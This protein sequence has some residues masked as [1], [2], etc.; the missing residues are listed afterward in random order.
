[1]FSFRSLYRR[2]FPGGPAF[3]RPCSR[4]QLEEL[5]GR[6][7]LSNAV[8]V[9]GVATEPTAGN[10]QVRG[11]LL[12]TPSTPFTI[13][14]FAT[15][16]ATNTSLG[17]VTVFTDLNGAASFT[18]TAALPP[19]DGTFFTATSTDLSGNTSASSAPISL[20]S[21]SI[22]SFTGFNISPS[23]NL[24][25]VTSVY[26]LLLNRA[27]DSSALG[28]VTSLNNGASPSGIVNDIESS[29]EYLTDQVTALY[30]RYL[31][32]PPDATGLQGW[33]SVLQSGGTL[34][35]VGEHLV[36]SDEFFQAQGGTN[37]AFVTALYSQVL[38]RAGSPS[39]I[40]GWVNFLNAGHTR[41]TVA[42]S[43]FTA[44]EYQNDLVEGYYTLYLQRNADTPG[45]T[46]WT[47]SLTTGSTDQQVAANILGSQEGYGVWS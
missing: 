17:S 4:P 43:F 10:V 29:T 3:S 24:A 33:V 8:P 13:N 7:V 2:R 27:P 5:E 15:N 16:N 25:Y 39:E 23:V 30:N 18:V 19:G 47:T 6:L 21:S 32:R 44:P 34:E 22:S 37:T 40:T 28:W 11:A 36:S 31:S 45:L 41:F 9:L 26:A 35:Q 20:T 42:T 14:V 12:A 1:M 46:T 38:G